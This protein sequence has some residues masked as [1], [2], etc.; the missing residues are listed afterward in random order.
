MRGAALVGMG[1]R[2][3]GVRLATSRVRTSIKFAEQ[4]VPG[5]VQV[6]GA[7]AFS[8]AHVFEHVSQTL[9][10]GIL[11]LLASVR[12]LECI[13]K[14]SQSCVARVGATGSWRLTGT[15]LRSR[16]SFMHQTP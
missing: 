7:G 5:S 15:W 10:E 13:R 9:L 6:M 1:G 3:V 16:R 2:A 12:H 11:G 14:A 4:L 8:V